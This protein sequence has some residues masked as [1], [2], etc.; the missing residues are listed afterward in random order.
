VHGDRQRQCL[1]PLL[2]GLHHQRSEQRLP[3]PLAPVQRH[4]RDAELGRLLVDEPVARL[5]GRE[6]AVPRRPH[7]L[8]VELGDHARVALAAPVPVIALEHRVGQ[9]G[10]HALAWPVRIPRGRLVQHLPQEAVV[11]VGGGPDVHEVSRAML[12]GWQP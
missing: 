3:D 12:R 11:V 1:E 5:L 8:A 4:H 9:R 10:D 6:Q 7:G 2:A